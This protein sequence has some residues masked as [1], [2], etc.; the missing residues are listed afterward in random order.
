M[1]SM[2]AMHALGRLTRLQHLVMDDVIFTSDASLQPVSSLPDLRS[3]VLGRIG[4]SFAKCDVAPLLALSRLTRLQLDRD[5]HEWTLVGVPVQLGPI[6][7]DDV[8][9]RLCSGLP[10]L[11][12][13]TLPRGYTLRDAGVEALRTLTSLTHLQVLGRLD[14]PSS[15]TLPRLPNLRKL[16][17]AAAPP[18]QLLRAMHL[19]SRDA[20]LVA[21][22]P[23]YA[24]DY[25]VEGS[26]PAVD[27]I[28]L[29]GDGEVCV[30]MG[31]YSE[32][33]ASATL[34]DMVFLTQH[35]LATR[36]VTHVLVENILLFCY[37]ARDVAASLGPLV[38]RITSLSFHDS[39]YNSRLRCPS[40]CRLRH[41]CGPCA[42]SVFT[43]TH[44]SQRRCWHALSG[45]TSCRCCTFFRAP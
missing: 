13:L 23:W 18:R 9:R 1:L 12:A 16:R 36:H 39:R 15:V 38:P 8:L 27:D 33:A 26:R 6:F 35:V 37:S 10:S 5:T 19:L 21:P 40:G 29:Q 30:D 20:R 7:D 22:V 11:C 17:V 43:V 2:G 14:L 42:S 28:N 32:A 4:E 3:C 24:C 34:A 44:G 31:A 45:V 25:Q 41:C